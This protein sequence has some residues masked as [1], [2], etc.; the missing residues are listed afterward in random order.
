MI[1]ALNALAVAADAAR[2]AYPPA[3]GGDQL[4]RFFNTAR[5]DSESWKLPIPVLYGDVFR[6]IAV[7]L[8]KPGTLRSEKAN[9]YGNAAPLA[10][11]L[12]ETISETTNDA[13]QQVNTATLQA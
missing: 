9:L 3:K 5:V 7:A 4:E 8:Q 6:N 11:L 13:V 12:G 10:L 1:N 2:S